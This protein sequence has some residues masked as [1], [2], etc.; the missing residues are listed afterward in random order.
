M[1]NVNPELKNYIQTNVFPEYALNDR[2]HQ[3][4]HVNYVIRRSLDFASQTPGT[5]PNM[6][7]TIAA[8]HDI[9]CHVDRERH[10]ELSAAA[11]KSDMGLRQFFSEEQ[12]QTMSDAVEDHRGSKYGPPRSVYGRIV[13]S[14]DR[15]TDLA[16]IMK[17]TYQYRE[18]T[19]DFEA[20]LVESHEILQERFGPG[21]KSVDKMYFKDAEY[22]KFIS[23]MRQALNDP[24]IFRARFTEAAESARRDMELQ[25]ALDTAA[26]LPQSMPQADFQTGF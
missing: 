1:E 8:Y 19:H 14:A 13:S 26:R 20:N 7:Y 22:E 25:K 23:D 12:I 17:K 11:L 9:K 10:E 6:A 24:E 15:P 21:G 4:G 5:D 3:M 2:G 18:N 16:A